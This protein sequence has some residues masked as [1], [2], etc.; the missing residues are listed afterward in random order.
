MNTRDLAKEIHNEIGRRG[1]PDIDA[2]NNLI[3]DHI[4]PLRDDHLI[5]KHT[6]E[7]LHADFCYY[8]RNSHGAASEI[9]KGKATR[10]AATAGEALDVLHYG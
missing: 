5:M 10:L 2:I 3:K 4:K 1:K 7:K 6:L 9:R 8:I